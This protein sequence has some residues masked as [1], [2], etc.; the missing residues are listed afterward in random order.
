[1]ERCEGAT[2]QGPKT[3]LLRKRV[4]GVQTPNKDTLASTLPIR[5][6]L[7]LPPLVPST[8]KAHLYKQHI[9]T[10]D[11]KE[12]CSPRGSCAP[13]RAAAARE[14]LV[15][16]QIN[17]P[18]AHTH[19]KHAQ[20]RDTKTHSALQAWGQVA[21]GQRGPITNCPQAS[22]VG[23]LESLCVR[24]VAH[25]GATAALSLSSTPSAFPNEAL[26]VSSCCQTH[27]SAAKFLLFCSALHCHK[28]PGRSMR[29]GPP[30]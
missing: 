7:A 10:A 13:A 24:D 14:G 15:T 21:A 25:T 19:M 26:T 20:A 29:H 17:A 9:N 5:R 28:S 1:M 30:K 16:I 3:G 4:T 2:G 18:R 8:A 6:L 12:V 27:S 23:H 11:R 22:L